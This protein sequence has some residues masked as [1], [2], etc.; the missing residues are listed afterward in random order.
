MKEKFLNLYQTM[1][2][3]R[4]FEERAGQVYAMGKI[5]GFCHLYIGQEAVAAGA[6][7]AAD[8]SIDTVITAYRCRGQYFA[9]GGCP[10]AAMAE[11][12][13][14][15]TGCSRGKGGSMHMFDPKNGFYGGHGIVGAQVALGT[16]LAFSHKYMR[17]GGVSLIFMGD[18]AANQG[19]V[20]ESFN[21]AAL[22][23]LPAI[24]IVENNSY[25]MG[26][27]ISRACAG[28]LYKRG[29]PFGITG[30]RIMGDDVVDIYNFFQGAIEQVRRDNFP[31]VV[32]IMTYRFRGHSMSDPGHYRT[33]EELD[34]AKSDRD[35]IKR[36]RDYLLSTGFVSEDELSSIESLQKDRVKLSIERAE[37]ASLPCEEELYTDILV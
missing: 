18:G 35:P 21:M 9:C 20:F 19:Q 27:A 8:L 6:C 2:L 22:Y 1:C 23:G 37:M 15:S 17:D 12:L 34:T 32:E 26:T 4:Y 30:H 33:R 14:K 31:L 7:S 24:Y 3:T 5:G 13:G 10:D 36:F 16:G 25:A 29:E 11:L 28:D